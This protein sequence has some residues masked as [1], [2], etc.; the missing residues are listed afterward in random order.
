MSAQL[1]KW[2]GIR[3]SVHWTVLIGLPWLYYHTRSAS[4][5]AIS[6][7]AF[8]FLLLAHELGHAAVALWRNVAVGEIRLLF[9]HGLCMHDEP[10]HEKDD[11]LIAWGGVAAQL[12]VLVIALGANKLLAILSP[13]TYQIASPL[14]QVLTATNILMM[15]INL[16]PVAPLDGAKA[17][18][19]LPMLWERAKGMSWVASLRKLLV[20]SERT[21]DRKLE[22]SSEQIVADLIDKLKKG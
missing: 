7:V 9:I 17:W 10:Y 6:F 8:F 15:I 4:A 19:I 13:F 20:A 21:R 18:R 1:G 3:I 11:V 5:T 16:I 14:F 2:R 22:E 12:V